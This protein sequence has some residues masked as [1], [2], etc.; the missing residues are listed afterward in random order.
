[1]GTI[2]LVRHGETAWNREGRAQGW[3]P[4]HLNERGRRQARALAEHLADEYSVDRFHSSDLMRT[5]ETA[6]ILRERI[7][8][9]IEYDRAWR[10]QDIG[11]LQGFSK[12]YLR[13]QFPEY[14]IAEAG[15]TASKRTPESGETFENARDRVLDAWESLVD[16][17]G[18]ETVLVVAHGGSIRMI[19]GD[20]MGLSVEEGVE[21]L[22]QGNCA[23]N[24]IR[25]DPDELLVAKEN[26]IEYRLS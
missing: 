15:Q 18:D 10:E 9:P 22:D 1:M 25:V 4:T 13:E 7:N 21:H 6:K 17:L 5:A 3:A 8:A 12:Q 2:V 14:T 26:D 11:V 16:D 19:L 23:V 20:V 24:E